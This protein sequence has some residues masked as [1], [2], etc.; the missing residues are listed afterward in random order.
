[1]PRHLHCTEHLTGLA[2]GPLHQ[3]MSWLL[4]QCSWALPLPPGCCEWF[5]PSPAA[6]SVCPL[7]VFP[8]R[9]L[10][11]PW[12]LV[13]CDFRLRLSRW[14]VLPHPL[15]LF[16]AS[17]V[18][19]KSLSLAGLSLARWEEA[20]VDEADLIPSW[21]SDPFLAWFK[22]DMVSALKVTGWFSLLLL[23]T[24]EVELEGGGPSSIVALIP[25]PPPPAPPVPRIF[26]F[27]FLFF[28]RNALLSVHKT[29][30][31]SEG[32]KVK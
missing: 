3:I 2:I 5:A 29:W 18:K 10:M 23:W 9:S 15:T 19:I 21:F 11:W 1:M 4:R 7:F 31:N 6:E 26:F 12:L 22:R 28:F 20:W 17:L 32:E 24:L 16:S 27:A 25:P 14:V 8:F 30:T 13:W